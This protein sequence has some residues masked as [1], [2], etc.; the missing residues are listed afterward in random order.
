MKKSKPSSTTRP[1]HHGDLR[2]T[3]VAA[4]VDLVRDTQSVEFSI[5]ELARRAGVSHNAP[6]KHFSDKRELLAAVSAAG[7]ELLAVRM[8][9][10][11]DRRTPRALI[12]AMARAYVRL[13]IENPAIY[14]LMFGGYLTGP[15]EDR[16]AIERTAAF[17]TR[18]LL[19]D[20]INKGALGHAIPQTARNERKIDG[21]IL[22]YWSLLHGLTLL[23]IDRLIG[24]T[25]KAEELSESVLEAMVDG[26]A[27]RIPLLPVDAWVGPRPPSSK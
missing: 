5:R 20:A 14:R 24:P 11:G 15:D 2:R 18:A 25:E 21:A 13:G 12:S 8:A 19:A 9:A 3:I 10:V 22:V 16:P 1:Y 26:L 27:T 23:L 6:Y 4:A 7:F 17:T